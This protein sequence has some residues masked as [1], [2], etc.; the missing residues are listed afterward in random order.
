[1]KSKLFI[2]MLFFNFICYGQCVIGLNPNSCFT[3]TGL[4]EITSGEM[5]Y[6]YQWYSKPINSTSPFQPILNA[7]SPSFTFDWA[8]YDQSIIKVFCFYDI[9]YFSTEVVL[10][11]TNCNLGTSNFVT[12]IPEIKL[13]PNPAKD[14]VE[15]DNLESGNQIEIFNSVGKRVLDLSYPINGKIDISNLLP[16]VYF[17]KTKTYNTF[18][19]YKF[20][21]I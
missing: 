5:Y 9:S 6:G 4:I 8:T 11:L 13:Y 19:N 20:I 12:D 17:L 18:S 14:Y 15:L 3:S 7:T 1:M 10:D 16:G 2:L 21:K